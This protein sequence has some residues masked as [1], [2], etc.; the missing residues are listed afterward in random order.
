MALVI[1]VLCHYLSL[2]LHN[3]IFVL[4]YFGQ[5]R[6]SQFKKEHNVAGGILKALLA[7][8]FLLAPKTHVKID[9]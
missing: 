9:G 2:T 8:K 7:A 3:F 6:L 5:L 4:Y 1:T